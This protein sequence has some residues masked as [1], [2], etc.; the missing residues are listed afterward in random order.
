MTLSIEKLFDASEEKSLHSYHLVTI[1]SAFRVQLFAA[2][3]QP[4]GQ[5]IPSPWAHKTTIDVLDLFSGHVMF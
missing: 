1:K 2:V 5:P 4:S 3:R